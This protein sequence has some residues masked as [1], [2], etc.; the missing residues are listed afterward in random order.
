[1]LSTTKKVKTRNH[2]TTK[3]LTS[4][5]DLGTWNYLPL[6]YIRGLKLNFIGGPY[7]QD[8]MLQGPLLQAST[9]KKI[10]KNEL[11]LIK[12]LVSF[13]S[14]PAQCV[15]R[16]WGPCSTFYYH[17]NNI[18]EAPSICIT[19]I[20]CPNVCIGKQTNLHHCK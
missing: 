10:P 19:C 18:L 7:S 6:L 14:R 5:V 17:H 12:I 2:N 11:N 15:W 13:C 16:V 20:C 3:L 8:K 1:M 4:I 9:C